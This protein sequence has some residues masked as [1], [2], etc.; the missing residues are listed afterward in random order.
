LICEHPAWTTFWRSCGAAKGRPLDSIKPRKGLGTYPAKNALAV[1]RLSSP[2]GL[3]IAES[4][5]RHD[6]L[7]RGQ[8]AQFPTNLQSNAFMV[9]QTQALMVMRLP[10][11]IL[12]PWRRPLLPPILRLSGPRTTVA[13]TSFYAQ[14]PQ[15][16]FLRTHMRS[17]SPVWVMNTGCSRFRSWRSLCAFGW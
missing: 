12:I 3:P 4:T 1:Q 16:D 13:H 15:Q 10:E 17:S 8:P 9:A 6:A 5:P 14:G 2:F 11:S 7:G